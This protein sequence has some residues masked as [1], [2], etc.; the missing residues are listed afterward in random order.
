[1]EINRSNEEYA[2]YRAYCEAEAQAEAQFHAELEMAQAEAEAFYAAQANNDARN[3]EVEQAAQ[4][5][6]PLT[7]LAQN[8]EHCRAVWE[9]VFNEAGTRTWDTVEHSFHNFSSAAPSTN[10]S[11]SNREVVL[12]N[13]GNCIAR[14]HLIRRPVTFNPFALVA[15][16]TQLGYAPTQP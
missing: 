6:K 3:R 4:P 10:I 14:D 13:R 16:L 7:D 8:P 15:L 11:C 9:C 1:M 12:T 2:A 5:T